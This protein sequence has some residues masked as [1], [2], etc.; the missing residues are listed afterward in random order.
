MT[1]TLLRTGCPSGDSAENCSNIKSIAPIP[2]EYWLFPKCKKKS[3]WSVKTTHNEN[4]LKPNKSI[5]VKRI[6]NHQAGLKMRYFE[7]P[8]H[9]GTGL[10]NYYWKTWNKFSAFSMTMTQSSLWPEQEMLIWQCY[11]AFAW[12]NSTCAKLFNSTQQAIKCRDKL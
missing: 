10:S 11:N 7:I 6:M 1:V 4:P 8:V 3:F 2:D 5:M 9:F 12:K